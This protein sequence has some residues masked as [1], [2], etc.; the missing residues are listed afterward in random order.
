MQSMPKVHKKVIG[1]VQLR[2]LS[3]TL[4]VEYN[5]IAW[6]QRITGINEWV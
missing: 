4:S 3:T 6:V 2:R 1:W 5:F